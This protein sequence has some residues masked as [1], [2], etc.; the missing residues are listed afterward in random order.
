MGGLFWRLV[1]FHMSRWQEPGH[2]F[3]QCVLCGR[4]FRIFKSQLVRPR[5]RGRFCTNKCHALAL[6]LFGEAL[7]SGQLE[8]LLQQM[9]AEEMKKEHG[10]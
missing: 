8:P 9:I 1:S 7:A 5:R 4:P 6:K 2:I 3:R 10:I